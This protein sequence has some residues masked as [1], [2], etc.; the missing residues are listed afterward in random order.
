MVTGKV[1]RL[2]LP[3]RLDRTNVKEH[4]LTQFVQTQRGC[5]VVSNDDTNASNLCDYEIILW[6]FLNPN[7]NAVSAPCHGPRD[8]HGGFR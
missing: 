1:Q 4:D 6:S 3:Q 5:Q 8:M 2:N 7:V